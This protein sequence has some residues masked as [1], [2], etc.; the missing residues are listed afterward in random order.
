MRFSI[1]W[2]GTSLENNTGLDGF[3]VRVHSRF[4]GTGNRTFVDLD[5][6]CYMVC[7]RC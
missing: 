4:V 1:D 3:C 6:F 7:E 5:T 2:V